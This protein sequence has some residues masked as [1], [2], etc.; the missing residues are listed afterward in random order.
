MAIY[1][2]NGHTPQVDKAAFVADNAVLAG[3][4]TLKDDGE[5]AIVVCKEYQNRHI[6]RRCVLAML[7]LAREKKMDAVKANIYA[8]NT[9]SQQMFK[10]VGFEPVADE[11][12][13]YKL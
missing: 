10:A 4:V 9:Q 3:D 12:Y 5:L 2:I 6:G 13:A 7:D 11:W 8:F 1:T